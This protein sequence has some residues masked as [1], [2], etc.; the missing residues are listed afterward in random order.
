MQEDQNAPGEDPSA[1]KKIIPFIRRSDHTLRPQMTEFERYM[2]QKDI[3][4]QS[5]IRTVF[6][7]AASPEITE[8]E[9]R[10]YV[11]S[12]L[13]KVVEAGQGETSGMLKV[14]IRQAHLEILKVQPSR[15]AVIEP[16]T[17]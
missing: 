17:P 16:N 13:G 9:L 14:E 3:V 7:R 15:F 12:A 1:D 2:K 4:E 6:V 10:L 11:R 8:K 5:P